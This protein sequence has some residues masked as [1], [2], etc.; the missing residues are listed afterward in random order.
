MSLASSEGLAI[1]LRSTAKEIRNLH[2]LVAV[3]SGSDATAN[4]AGRTIDQQPAPSASIRNSGTTNS[5]SSQANDTANQS[6]GPPAAANRQP[7]SE[8]IPVPTSSASTSVVAN[9]ALHRGGPHHHQL[10]KHQHL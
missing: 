1:S 3:A 6:D 5:G 7:V 10:H 9:N 8:D 2:P 4:S